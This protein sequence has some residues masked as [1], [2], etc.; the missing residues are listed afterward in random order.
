MSVNRN[1]RIFFQFTNF[2]FQIVAISVV[3]ASFLSYRVRR[4][5]W[6]EKIH[7]LSLLFEK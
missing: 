2:Q 3:L 1:L 6:K 5:N 4:S 7:F